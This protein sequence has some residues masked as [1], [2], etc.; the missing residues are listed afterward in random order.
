MTEPTADWRGER[1]SVKKGACLLASIFYYYRTGRGQSTSD[2]IYRISDTGVHRLRHGIQTGSCNNDLNTEKFRP[3]QTHKRLKRTL[4]LIRQY[5]TIANF[6][7][8]PP[9]QTHK[10]TFNEN[11]VLIQLRFLEFLVCETNCRLVALD[12]PQN[13]Q[14]FFIVLLKLAFFLTVYVLGAYFRTLAV[15]IVLDLLCPLT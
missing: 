1:L 13:L 11:I 6:R 12:L 4:I 7:G 14:L 3:S 15:I 2:T 5:K 10:T 9:F 8:R